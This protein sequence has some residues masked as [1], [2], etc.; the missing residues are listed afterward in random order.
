MKIIPVMDLMN[1]LVVRGVAGHRDEYRPIESCLVPSAKPMEVAAA[2]RARLG[3]SELYVADL[4]AI[5]KDQP[6]RELYERLADAGF[7][8]MVDAGL[9]MADQAHQIINAGIETTS[10]VMGLETIPGPELVEE[11][12]HQIPRHRLILSLDMQ[13][14][15]LLGN[16]ERWSCRDPFELAC[17]AV[18]LGVQR[19]IVLDLAQVGVSGGLA[20][21]E[22]CQRLQQ[23]FPQLEIIT[24]GGVRNVDDLER[25]EAA[26]VAAALV[27]TSL[28]N[29]T[30]RAIDVRR[31][32]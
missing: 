28:H 19:M 22:L 1:G 17:Q 31:L 5:L 21:I 10:V 18:K 7:Q 23:E 13:G 6:N 12:C 32:E 9:K 11:L 3:L 8:I 25:L 16:L 30:I 24:G 20:T 29:G 2:F 27:A 26:G 4:D 14:G 15:K